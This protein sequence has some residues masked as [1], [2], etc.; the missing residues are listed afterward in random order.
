MANKY[1]GKKA[2]NLGNQVLG[3]KKYFPAFEC[4]WKGGVVI[5]TG[6]IRP[7]AISESYKI[8]ICYSLNKV[9]RVWVISPE[10]VKGPNGEKIP[11]IYSKNELCLYYP[12]YWEWNKNM[13]IA[14]T[15]L[16]WSSLWL[17]Y[18][19]LWHATGQWLGGGIHPRRNRM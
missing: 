6:T 19:E 7:S 12:K 16:P 18:Y 11:H 5:W 1:F 15:I 3:M 10:L 14:E 4:N 2:I 17:Y 13:V 9:P 8:K